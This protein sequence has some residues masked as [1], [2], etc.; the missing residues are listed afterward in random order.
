[1]VL[2]QRRVVDAEGNVTYQP[3]TDE[4][5]RQVE[6]LVRNAVGVTGRRGD[7]I[8]VV[9]V[10]FDVPDVPEPVEEPTDVLTLAQTFQKPAVALMAII[11]ASVLAFRLLGTLKSAPASARSATSLPASG[12]EDP[13]TASVGDGP[14]SEGVSVKKMGPKIEA[15]ELGIND[16]KMTA[17]VL[18]AWMKDS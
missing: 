14:G 5:L 12:G 1:V 3:R 2:N 6:S 10:P 13:V 4:E 7:A 15:P 9:S 16:P 18:Q 8:S 11:M 17:R